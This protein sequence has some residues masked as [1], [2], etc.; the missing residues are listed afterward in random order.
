MTR[1]GHFRVP[2]IV[3]TAQV[4]ETHHVALLLAVGATA[5]RPF[6][7]QQLAEEHIAGGSRNYGNAI[8]GGLRKVL[9]RMG[10]STLA[11]YRNAQ[12]FEVIGLEEEVCREFF[13]SAPHCADANSL[14]Q[15][16]GDYLFNHAQAFKPEFKSPVDSGLYRFRKEG[17]KHGTSADLMRKLQAHTKNP[18]TE[19]YQEFEALALER[20]PVAIRDLLD[21]TSAK[22]V[23]SDSVEPETA[24]LGRFSVQA[25]SV[26]AISPEAHGHWRSP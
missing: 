1:G 11:S 4:I 5:V 8:D 7:A 3:E 21:F 16:L 18:T 20:E 15:L 17:E 26:G 23:P 24:I 13:E 10:I 22:P 25:M 12:L 19:H 9:S 14:E 6:L 2:L